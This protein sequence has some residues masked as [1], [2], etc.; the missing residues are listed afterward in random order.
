MVL[1]IAMDILGGELAMWVCIFPFTHHSKPREKDQESTPTSMDLTGS[2]INDGNFITDQNKEEKKKC[3]SNL[4]GAP[5]QQ[6]GQ[7]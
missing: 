6:T 2:K 7:N 4:E 3:L 5:N 1:I